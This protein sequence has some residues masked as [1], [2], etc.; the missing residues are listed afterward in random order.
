MAAGRKTGKV[1]I[2]RDVKT[3]NTHAGH[4]R[5]LLDL[6]KPVGV[7]NYAQLHEHWLQVL[8]VSVL[9][10][11]FYQK[12][13][14]WYLWALTKAEFPQIRPEEDKIKNDV[15]Q[16]ESLIR[17]LS[18]L[19]FCWFMKEKGLINPNLFNIDYLRKIL[20]GFEGIRSEQTIYYKAILQNLFLQHSINQLTKERL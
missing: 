9:N 17:L 11:Q 16:S 14:N 18:R 13:F 15:H 20:K 8:D 7:N 12:L 4:Q 3:I 2:L 6:V 10:K 5:I 19:L 1:I